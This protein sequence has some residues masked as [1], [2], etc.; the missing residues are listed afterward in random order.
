[1][2]DR[3]LAVRYAKALLSVFPDPNQAAGTERFLSGLREAMKESG[4]FRDLML[5]PAFTRE[6]RKK[7]VR[8]MVADAGLPRQ[9]ANFMELLVDNNRAASIPSIAEVF[10]EEREKALGIQPAELTTA[11]PIDSELTERAQRAVERLTG[12]RVRLT[13]SVEPELLGGAVTRIG[14][15]VYDGSLRTQLN[16]LQNRMARD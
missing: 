7:V 2:K 12:S 15:R 14:S 9:V 8:S 10:H 5:D 13:C 6:A 1:M 16:R 3:K 4:E 11:T